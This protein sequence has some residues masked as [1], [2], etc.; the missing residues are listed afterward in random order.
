[1]RQNNRL[2]PTQVQKQNDMEIRLLLRSFGD[3][4]RILRENVPA[5]ISRDLSGAYVARWDM[6]GAALAPVVVA[7]TP[8]RMRN[9][10]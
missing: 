4:I 2:V 3:A 1:M 6:R 8:L 5:Q 9:G 7:R 10:R